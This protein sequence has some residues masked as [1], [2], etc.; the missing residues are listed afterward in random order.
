MKTGVFFVF[1][2]HVDKMIL[3]QSMVK[4]TIRKIWK[5]KLKTNTYT[6]I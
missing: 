5:W 2:P 4:Q 6:C 1:F 3:W